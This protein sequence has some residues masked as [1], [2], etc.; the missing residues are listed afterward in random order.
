VK[1]ENIDDIQLRLVVDSSSVELLVNEGEY[2][3]TS[4]VYPDKACE[5]ISVFTSNGT[6]KV[7]N[8]YV[9]SPSK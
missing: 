8:G 4:L 6:I 5:S 7:T 2:S 3:V 9:S 1:L